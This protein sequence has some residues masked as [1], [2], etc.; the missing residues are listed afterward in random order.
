MPHSPAKKKRPKALNNRDRSLGAGRG[1]LV[2]WRAIVTNSWGELQLLFLEALFLA[3][4]CSSLTLSTH[5]HLCSEQSFLIIRICRQFVLLVLLYCCPTIFWMVSYSIAFCL[6]TMRSSPSLSDSQALST[7]GGVATR[8]SD[9]IAIFSWTSSLTETA[10]QGP[11]WMKEPFQAWCSF[12]AA[13]LWPSC[14]W[15]A[16]ILLTASGPVSLR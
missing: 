12:Q 13:Y 4:G 8:Q 1:L 9:A 7:A 11:S 6:D 2:G 14:P 16:L 3:L 5:L 10:S 15:P